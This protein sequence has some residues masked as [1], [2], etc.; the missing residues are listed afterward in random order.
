[1][2][3]FHH[4]IHALNI[5][6]GAVAFD[7]LKRKTIFHTEFNPININ[8]DNLTT[9]RDQ[10]APYSFVARTGEGESFA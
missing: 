10:H 9:I 6:N 1:M 4:T 7:D 8:F 2:T 5:T 3:N